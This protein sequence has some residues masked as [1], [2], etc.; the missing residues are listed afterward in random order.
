MLLVIRPPELLDT[1]GGTGGTGCLE[2]KPVDGQYV[3]APCPEPT[4]KGRLSP[5][6][7]LPAAHLDCVACVA[8]ASLDQLVRGGAKL[9]PP[10]PDK[11]SAGGNMLDSL[12]PNMVVSGRA[13]E[14]AV[15]AAVVTWREA[16]ALAG[17]AGAWAGWTRDAAMRCMNGE[18]ER[19]VGAAVAETGAGAA[20][21]CRKRE[22]LRWDDI[23]SVFCV[24]KLKVQ[25]E[26]V[27]EECV[28]TTRSG[29]DTPRRRTD[30][31]RLDP[32]QERVLYASFLEFQR[33]HQ[34]VRKPT[35]TPARKQERLAAPT[36]K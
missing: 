10:T 6:A 11:P 18:T 17:T 15:A 12:P 13:A 31:A 3:M 1:R 4:V 9:N 27:Y 20:L 8:T 24:A 22:L 16:A 32:N 5:E 19:L 36:P 7:R 35:E 33:K 34:S 14:V 21:L 26:N 28:P 2:N 25:S 29:T 23:T 30:R